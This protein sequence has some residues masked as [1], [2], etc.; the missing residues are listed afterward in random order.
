MSRL[1]ASLRSRLNLKAQGFR[2]IAEGV[3]YV[4][5]ISSWVLPACDAGEFAIDRN[6][7][8]QEALKD[9]TL[10]GFSG[11]SHFL[12]CLLPYILVSFLFDR[13]CDSPL[14]VLVSHILVLLCAQFSVLELVQTPRMLTRLSAGRY[15]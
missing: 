5:P 9:E 12:V 7:L 15:R 6:T 2:S 10:C 1:R 4:I 11:T 14:F 13:R 8:H 3:N